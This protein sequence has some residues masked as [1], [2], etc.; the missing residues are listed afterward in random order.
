MNN[1]IGIFKTLLHIDIKFKSLSKSTNSYGKS[2]TRNVGKFL[3]ALKTLGTKSENFRLSTNKVEKVPCVFFATIVLKTWSN[4]SSIVFYWF[5][6]GGGAQV[7]K[8]VQKPALGFLRTWWKT[9]F[10]NINLFLSNFFFPYTL[11]IFHDFLMILVNIERK[12]REKTS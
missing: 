8:G 5:S 7:E 11:N 3:R 4:I 12:H 1:H 10:G 6:I 2:R 9:P